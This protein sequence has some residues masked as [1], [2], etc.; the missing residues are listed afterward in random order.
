[1]SASLVF[2]ALLLLLLL[3]PA[4]FQDK[5]LVKCPRPIDFYWVKSF[6][7]LSNPKPLNQKL[8]FILFVPTSLECGAMSIPGYDLKLNFLAFQHKFKKISRLYILENCLIFFGMRRPS[9]LRK[10]LIARVPLVAAAPGSACG[11]RRRGGT[12]WNKPRSQIR[13]VK[14]PGSKKAMVI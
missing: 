4:L 8:C 11:H 5:P 13:S 2:F 7:N 6:R 12:W 1:M 10:P 14:Y 3:P 9:H